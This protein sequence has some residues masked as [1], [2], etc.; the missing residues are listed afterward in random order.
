MTRLADGES[1][2]TGAAR[3]TWMPE[4]TADRGTLRDS[5][6]CSDRAVRQSPAWGRSE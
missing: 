4:R 1:A 6:A 3:P 2:I 5:P